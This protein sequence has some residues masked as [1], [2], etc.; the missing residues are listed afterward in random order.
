MKKPANDTRREM[1]PEE[2]AAEALRVR[3]HAGALHIRRVVQEMVVEKLHPGYA[4][5]TL[6]KFG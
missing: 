6:G 1:T 2:M 5:G 4:R 3:R